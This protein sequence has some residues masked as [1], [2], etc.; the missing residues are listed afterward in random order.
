MWDDAYCLG[1][2]VLLRIL[3]TAH[4]VGLHDL[5]SVFGVANI[6]IGCSGILT[7]HFNEDLCTAW[8]ILQVLGDIENYAQ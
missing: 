8:M 3:E 6:L 1:S 5:A 2:Y 7:C 4:E